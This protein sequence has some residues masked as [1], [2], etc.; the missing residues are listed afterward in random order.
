MPCAS[1]ELRRSSQSTT[2]NP[3]A[4]VSRCATARLFSARGPSVPSMFF[5]R[6]STMRST[7]SVRTTS[8]IAATARSRFH[9][10]SVHARPHSVA[11]ASESASPMRA[12]P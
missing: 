3:V 1:M 9:S 2:S 4:S 6:P 10:V 5:G 11:E 8:A 7:P 12:S